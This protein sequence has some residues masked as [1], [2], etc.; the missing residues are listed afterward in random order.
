MNH[1]DQSY[2]QLLKAL[3]QLE[4]SQKNPEQLNCKILDGI[5]TLPQCPPNTLN[6][7]IKSLP[8]QPQQHL[9]LPYFL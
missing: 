8:I 6:P 3:R 7:L 9:L 4:I 1:T 5:T 2:E